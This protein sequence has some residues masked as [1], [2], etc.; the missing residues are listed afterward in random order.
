MSAAAAQRG[1]G[2][3][4]GVA[5]AQQGVE[6]L[7]GEVQLPRAGEGRLRAWPGGQEGRASW[8]RLF[9]FGAWCV[10]MRPNQNRKHPGKCSRIKWDGYSG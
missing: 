1:R 6:V 7:L 4:L 10:I 3:G 5:G 2:L 9:P 8:K